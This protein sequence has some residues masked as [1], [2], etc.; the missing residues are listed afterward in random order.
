MSNYLKQHAKVFSLKDFT[1][2]ALN[3]DVGDGDHT[4]L[5]IFPKNKTGRMRLLVKQEG[6]L[7]GVT[8]A[9]EIFKLIDKKITLSAQLKDGDWVKKGEV[10]F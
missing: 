4:S 5:S 2:N 10:A 1:R 6:V 8:A 3:E 7:A 9:K